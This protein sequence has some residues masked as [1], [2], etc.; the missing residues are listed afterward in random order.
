VCGVQLNYE[1][2]KNKTFY[3][4]ITVFWVVAPCIL[5]DVSEVLAAS[6]IRMMGFIALMMEVARTL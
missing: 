3:L 2:K 1:N 4:K 6:I 5:V